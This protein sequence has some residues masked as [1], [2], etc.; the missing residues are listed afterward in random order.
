MDD[1]LEVTNFKRAIIKIDIEGHEH[2]A[3]AQSAK[4]FQDV[5]ILYIFMEW[6]KLR[7]YYGSEADDSEDKRLVF[8][9]IETLTG[10]GYTAC[11]LVLLNPL[12]PV[13]WYGWPDDIVWQH[14]DAKFV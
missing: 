11:G 5:R 13:Y 3:F 14:K 10:R 8:G 12:D 7:G 9:L 1:L 2:R 6:I 4:L